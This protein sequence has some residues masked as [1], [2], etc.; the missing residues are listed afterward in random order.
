[1]EPKIIFE[2]EEILV[3]NKPAG[4]TVNKAETTVGETTVQDWVENK[5]KVQSSK[6]K[7]DEESDFYKR[8]GIVHRIDKETS[9]ILITAKTPEAFSNLQAQ[10]KERKVKKTYTAL[11]HGKIEGDG[12]IVVP[13]GRLPWNRMRFGV[14]A[15]G[16]EAVTKYHLLSVFGFRLSASGSSVIQSIGQ[17]DEQI[18]LDLKTENRKLTTEYLS[19][20]EVYPETGRTHQIRVHLKYINH[21]IFADELYAGR[22]TARRDRKYLSR[23]FLHASKISFFHPKKGNTLSF[24]SPLPN[25]LQTFLDQLKVSS[26]TFQVGR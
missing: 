10:F 16:K 14:L 11:T 1:M 2:D 17:T 7:I 13:V 5:F 8:A 20:L 23:F 3:L 15:G 24:E 6:F 9:G 21:P 26:P 4:M 12:E 25:D 22:K 18:D 19:L